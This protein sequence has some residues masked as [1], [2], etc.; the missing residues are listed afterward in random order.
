MTHTVSFTQPIQQLGR[1]D[2]DFKVRTE[3]GVLGTL[4]VSKGALVWVPPNHCY[5]FK[6]GWRDFDRLARANG[7]NGHR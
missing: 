6:I 1:A 7:T 3:E 2:I 5:G 4:K